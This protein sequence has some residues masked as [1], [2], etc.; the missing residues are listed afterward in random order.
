MLLL[1]D[2]VILGD[3][4]TV[5]DRAGVQI[6]G[7]GRLGAVGP[8]EELLGRFAG[9]EVQDLGDAAILPG[10]FDMHVHLGYYYSQPDRE[11]YN[12]FMVAYYAAKQARLALE[13]GITTVRDLSSPHGLCKTL[14]E[15]GETL[16]LTAVRHGVP[17]A[18]IANELYHILFGGIN[19]AAVS[20]GLAAVPP[21]KPG[22][23]RYLQCIQ[24]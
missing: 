12:D 8:A 11:F 10:L 13:L 23:G 2:H 21:R 1:A 7:A 3:G 5:L 4:K 14:R 22:E 20:R 24:G 19:E 17:P 9:E 18:E 6:D 15:A 16:S